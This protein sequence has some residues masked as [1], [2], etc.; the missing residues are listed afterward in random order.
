MSQVPVLEVDGK[1]ISQSTREI[2]ELLV[3]GVQP[4]QS[5]GLIPKLGKEEWQ[6]WAQ[7]YITKGFTEDPQEP[8]FPILIPRSVPLHSGP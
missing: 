7:F 1:N 6:N 5:L 4:L 8:R 2:T 3:S